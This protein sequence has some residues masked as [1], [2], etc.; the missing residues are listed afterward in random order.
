MYRIEFLEK[1]LGMPRG[2]EYKG[3]DSTLSLGL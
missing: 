1:F 2:K 3:I